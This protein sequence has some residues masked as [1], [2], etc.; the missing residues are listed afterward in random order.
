MCFASNAHNDPN[1]APQTSKGDDDA[2]L[3]N[4][5]VAKT[6]ISAILD[7]LTTT[8][9]RA[10]SADNATQSLGDELHCTGYSPEVDT[11]EVCS[12][13]DPRTSNLAHFYPSTS[14]DSLISSSFTMVHRI[15]SGINGDVFKYEWCHG[16]E[17]VAVAVKK[18]R[19]NTLQRND[20]DERD[21]RVIHTKSCYR[22][23]K[24]DGLT[25]IGIL[26]YLSKQ[27]DVPLYLLK[28]HGVF[29]EAR[30][31]T[32]LVTEYANGGELF[33]VAAAGGLK[34]EKVK[35]YMW[36]LLS[37]VE[38]LHRHNIGHRDISLENVLLKDD[39]VKLMD[40]GMAVQCRSP[41]GVPLRY[42]GEVGKAFYRPPEGYVPPRDQVTVT[43]PC[44]AKPGDIVMTSV[45]TSFLCQVR[46]PQDALPGK[47]CLAD[48]W[49]YAVVPAD[50]FALG[51]CLFIL[52]FQAPPWE[53]AK[54]GNRFFAHVRKSAEGI[55]SLPKL[56]GK[57]QL[58]ST[59]GMSMLSD[60]MQTDPGKRPSASD[61]LNHKWFASLRDIPMQA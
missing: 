35:Q 30:Q 10:S 36:Q 50:I 33:N 15:A 58:L 49:G 54:P 42:Y 61:C 40:Y 52:S 38:Y 4:S 28:M 53:F 55:A 25:E 19:N 18:L 23:S 59:P 13:N 45:Q 17:S 51:V 34:E 6:V 48:V 32:W 31:Y 41:A 27:Q 57:G 47:E 1:G 56:W 20:S 2:D 22:H 7:R 14:F 26:Q 8:S 24:E 3:H 12:V 39:V 9:T 60:M 16:N 46:L 5:I 11:T 29:A 43:A 44:S 37:A 21:E